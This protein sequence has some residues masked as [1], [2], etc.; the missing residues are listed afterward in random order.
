MKNLILV[1]ILVLGSLFVNGQDKK[2]THLSD[3]L[4]KV[5]TFHENGEL[6]QSGKFI[7]TSNDQILKTGQWLKFN[8]MGDLMTVG[9]FTDDNRNGKWIYY[10]YS[11]LVLAEVTYIDGKVFK[12]EVDRD[13]QASITL[14]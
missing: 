6:S 10:S 8:R 2:I 13:V 7:K 3:S 11:N 14:N 5:E 4:Y 9:F 12:T 1:T